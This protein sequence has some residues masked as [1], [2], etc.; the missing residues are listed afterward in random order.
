MAPYLTVWLLVSCSGGGGGG[1]G[2]GNLQSNPNASYLTPAAEPSSP[3]VAGDWSGSLEYT[4]STGL[5]QLK[6][7]EG[8]ARRSGGLP[9]GQGVRIAIIDSGID[10]TH[11]DLGNLAE[12]SWSA[13]G[14][15]IVG[16][17]HATFVAGIAGASRTQS[18]D[19]NDMHGMAYRATLVNFQASRPSQT[20]SNGGISFGT[21][22]LVDALRAAS[23]LE[24]GSSAVES[25][26]FNLSLGAPSN[27]DSTFAKLRSAMIAAAAEDKIMV[28]A[29]GNEGDAQ[30]IYPAAY[31]D[32]SGIAG[33]AIVVGNLTASDLAAP[34]SNLCGD[35]RDY[36][37]F[38]PG[39]SVKS[40]LNG[41]NYGVGSGT[42]FAAPYVAGAAAVVKAAFPGVSS[43]DVV[44]RLLLTAEDLGAAGVDNT[45]GR[46]K[47]DLEAAMAPVGPTGF[48]IAPTV[49]GQL[50]PVS[51]TALYLGPGLVLN[52]A[53]RGHLAQ[54]VAVDSMG[55][56]FPTDL[57]EA[58]RT[59]ERDDGLAAFL[60]GDRR[61][62]AA[63]GGSAAEIVAF[64]SQDEMPWRTGTWSS[65]SFDGQIRD[66]KI[67][68]L[69][70]AADLGGHTAIF[71][72]VNGGEEERF[73]LEAGLIERQAT[74]MEADAFFGGHAGF[75][76]A[77]SGAGFHFK[78]AGGTEIALAAYD[79]MTEDERAEISL[80][81]LDV[82]QM[83]PGEIELRL[84]IGLQQEEGG[85]AG[86][87]ASGA[88]GDETS[89][90][91]RFL[92]I[93]FLA[94]VTTDIDAF[95]TYSRGRSSIG[96]ADQAL[97]ADWSDARS[98]AFG[99][100]VVIRNL[101][102]DDDGLTLVA[103]QPF[104]QENVKVTVDLP[105]A[106]AP[107]GS[108]VTARKR[109]DFAPA[110]REVAAE[111]GYRLPLDPKGDH[112]LQA[113][114]FVRINPDHD[115]SRDPEAGI[116]LAYRWRF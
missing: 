2:G 46:G 86:G 26:I 30:P 75:A 114:G 53:S 22:D 101:V 34:S 24:A 32:D 29:A 63:I 45:F 23:G 107:D 71:A 60:S 100:G 1:S 47:L 74:L 112:R 57:A 81:R 69:R 31:A 98:E 115:D 68:P 64:V 87:E 90:R 33:H 97:L 5:A 13:G 85:F 25:D 80:Q 48:P 79:S 103:G 99:A 61:S 41:G 3:A 51:Q 38:A 62:A 18:G 59:T 91:S 106:R 88:F 52:G 9:G 76:A 21:N 4:N 111:V 20:A 36:C 27:S 11:P 65:T 43:R 17:S 108:V 116:G 28:L 72:S 50:V 42:S 93:S 94:P 12:T 109:L 40:T 105:V 77:S 14:E 7:A 78:P 96:D 70:F 15:A 10:V 83:I 44:D 104:R 82:K 102:S 55:F 54:A 8:Y 110:A 6:A 84:G 49:D 95:A 89:A 66:G 92:T 35:T 73:G 67:V 58:V 56:P 19:P 113:A 16:D 39:T 37:L